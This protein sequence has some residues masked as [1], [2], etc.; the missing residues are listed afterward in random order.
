MCRPRTKREAQSVV[1]FSAAVLLAAAVGGCSETYFDR[2]DSVDLRAGNAIAANEA[3]ETVDPW[4]PHSGDAQLAANG[5]RMQSAV[6]RYRSNIVTQPV[7]PLMLETSNQTPATAQS[8]NSTSSAPPPSIAPGSTTTTTTV[9]TA[10]P[11]SQ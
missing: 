5:Q 8:P 2:R 3:A 7:D 4:P 10:P 11:A 1:R 6:E 9:V